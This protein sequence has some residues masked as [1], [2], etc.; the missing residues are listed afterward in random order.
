MTIQQRLQAALRK[1][2]DDSGFNLVGVVIA[3]MNTAILAPV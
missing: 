2:R 1:Q 3:L